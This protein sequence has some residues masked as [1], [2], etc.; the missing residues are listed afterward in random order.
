MRRQANRGTS[1]HGRS[2]NVARVSEGHP[3]T[4]NVGKAQQLCI[5]QDRTAGEQQKSDRS[6]YN[7]KTS[8]DN[9]LEQ[10]DI[11]LR[12]SSELDFEILKWTGNNYRRRNTELYYARQY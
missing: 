4:V 1:S 2:P 6:R 8:K 7:K 5:S 9:S 12:E 10:G 3:I 11:L